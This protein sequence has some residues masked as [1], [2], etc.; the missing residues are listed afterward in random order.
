MQQSP[1]Q[2]QHNLF[3]L[4]PIYK[5]FESK[6]EEKRNWLEKTKHIAA[7]AAVASLLKYII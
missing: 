7:A 2:T 4:D 3:K 1:V 6:I 5:M